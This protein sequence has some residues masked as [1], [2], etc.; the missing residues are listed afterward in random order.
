MAANTESSLIGIEMAG[1]HGDLML[2][3]GERAAPRAFPG[4]TP[5]SPAYA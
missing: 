3:H 1:I 4:R 2:G 5:A